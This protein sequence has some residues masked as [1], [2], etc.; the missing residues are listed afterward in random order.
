MAEPNRLSA[1]DVGK[2]WR[3]ALQSAIC[4]LL[5]AA[6]SEP[7]P[8]ETLRQ[9]EQ[10]R[11]VR[12]IDGDA[13]VL[14]TGLS[15]RLVGIE[16]PAPERRS[17]AGQPF[18]EKSA[19]MLEDM[20][21]GRTVRLIYPG[22]T[23]DRYDRALAYVETVD[24]LGPKLWLNFEMIRR[25]GARVRIYPDTAPLGDLLYEAERAAR[26]AGIGLWSLDAYDILEA[27]T[28]VAEA[29]G[30][31]IIYGTIDR[32]EGA[33]QASDARCQ[34]S[35]SGASLVLMAMPGASDLCDAPPRKAEI[36][37]YVYDGKMEITHGLNV[38]ALNPS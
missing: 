18:A 7:H 33:G 25:G 32:V 13:L 9:G 11:V 4:W 38:H 28:L 14:D 29:R 3:A 26:E 10:G 15:V 24:N 17:R 5:L 30:F 16:A 34:L 31:Q 36:R 2:M 19:R 8:L 12:I 1:K 22:L 27:D 21:M 23:R 35:L 37:G 20:A 6:C